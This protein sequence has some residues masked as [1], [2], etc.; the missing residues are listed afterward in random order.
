MIIDTIDQIQRYA[1]VHPL[2]PQVFDF[3]K[4][5]NLLTLPNGKHAILNDDIFVLIQRGVGQSKTEAKLECHRKYID[6]QLVLD[7]T[8]NM[9]WKPL[10]DCQQAIDSFNTT[11]DVQ[12]FEDLPLNWLNTQPNKFCIFFPEDAHSGMVSEHHL[13]KAVFKIAVKP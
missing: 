11:N 9:G 8:D 12:F 6:I 13:H 1:A 7:G 10:A 4:T 5:T 2:F 3:I